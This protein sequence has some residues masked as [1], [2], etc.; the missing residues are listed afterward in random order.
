MASLLIK[1]V[2]QA[3]HDWLKRE[4]R[5]NRRSMNQQALA[6]LEAQMGPLRPVDFPEPL[7][8]SKPITAGFIDS[9]KREGRA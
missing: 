6:I 9:A 4:A 3:L 5:R 2:P 8:P 7:L 1:N